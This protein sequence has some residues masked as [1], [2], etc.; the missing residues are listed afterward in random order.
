MR[1]VTNTERAVDVIE[2]QVFGSARAIDNI[3]DIGVG[4]RRAER[5]IT[6]DRNIVVGRRAG[7]NHRIAGGQADGQSTGRQR[8]RTCEC[9]ADVGVG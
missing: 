8:L 1:F 5:H 4:G 3:D 6:V 2:N 7:Q 9:K